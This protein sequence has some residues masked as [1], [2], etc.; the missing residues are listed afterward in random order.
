MIFHNMRGIQNKHVLQ[1]CEKSIYLALVCLGF[2]FIYQGDVL[3]KF[4]LK[5]TNFAEYEEPITELPTYF[6]WLSPYDSRLMLG[7]NFNMSI[8]D[9]TTDPL[10][11]ISPSWRQGTK[12]RLGENLVGDLKLT[13]TELQF[14]KDLEMRLFKIRP[15]NFTVGMPLDYTL[16]F[17]FDNLTA[18]SHIVLALIAEN[19][20][21]SMYSGNFYDGE[22]K[23]ISS[24]LGYDN[25][26]FVTPEK[27]I[28]KP[29]VQSCRIQPYNEELA[30]LI[31]ENILAKCQTPCKPSNSQNLFDTTP[32]L[33]DN[34]S[35][36]EDE[37]HD[38][39]QCFG[40]VQSSAQNSIEK[41]PCIKVQYRANG[42]PWIKTNHT[43]FHL[44]YSL[45]HI[46]V[47]EE[48]MIYDL[49]AMIGAV[50]GTMGIFIGISF[51]D[52]SGMFFEL[53]AGMGLHKLE[54]KRK[55]TLVPYNSNECERF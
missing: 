55:N 43:S 33:R 34:L 5:R 32:Y 11:S 9:E 22:P 36:C 10:N 29:E 14:A 41:R 37:E 53:V 38:G 18:V 27:F 21:Y 28:Y 15:E 20:S 6:V 40:N 1:L 30:K 25:W 26:Y 49:L 12:L 8:L 24:P 2:Y 23:D 48:Y 39:I 16:K 4:Q 13:C 52:L 3:Q 46:I 19:N 17:T 51:A 7:D 45:P 54:R 31:L 50:G 42:S 47:K 44:I 35:F